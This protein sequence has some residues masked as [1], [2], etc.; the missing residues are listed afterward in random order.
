[1]TVRPSQ[2]ITVGFVTT[3]TESAP[4]R[5][6]RH[7]QRALFDGIAERY[8]SYRPGYPARVV[9]FVTATAGLGRGAA[10][11]E[12]GCG[13]GQLTERLASSGFR[14]TAIDLGPALIAAA[15]RRLGGADVSFQV[16]PFEDLAAADASF[17]LVI[18]S[19]AFHWIDPEVAFSKSARLLRPGGWLALLGSEERYDDPVGPAL[20][21]AWITHGDTGGAWQR[22]PSDPEAFA[23][24]GLFG[25]PACLIDRQRTVLPAADV[26]ALEST[27][28][29]FLSWPP[30]TQRRFTAE[31]R[32]LLEPSPDVPLTRHTSV[33]MAQVARLDQRWSGWRRRRQAIARN[34]LH[35]NANGRPAASSFQELGLIPAVYRR[36]LRPV[37][38]VQQADQLVEARGQDDDEP[39]WLRPGVPESMRDARRHQHGR[40]SP[41]D[42]LLVCEP[43]AQRPGHHMP[44]LVIRMVDM[45]GRDLARQPFSRPVLYN[46]TRAPHSQPR[47]VIVLR[48]D[49]HRCCDHAATVHRHCRPGHTTT[50]DGITTSC[51]SIRGRVRPVAHK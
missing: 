13:T 28:A 7:Y 42:D 51:W 9:E 15:R 17:D 18:S 35:A 47:S 19:A 37:C 25:T 40:T 36:V 3:G 21:A 2:G 49:D 16:T 33:T 26:I 32:R 10:V 48:H 20:T 1:V 50:P 11:L 31:L 6:K 23:A 22:R 39:R 4:E 27:R 41:G 24:T 29:T 34:S 38:L 14:L 43:E 5:S 45:K 30:G 46:Q 8:E 44:R 12:V